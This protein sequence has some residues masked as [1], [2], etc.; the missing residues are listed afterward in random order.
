MHPVRYNGCPVCDDGIMYYTVRSSFWHLGGFLDRYIWF[1]MVGMGIN[2]I[3]YMLHL[4]SPPHYYT[5]QLSKGNTRHMSNRWA[6][7]I[8]LYLFK[9]S[10]KAPGN[11]GKEKS[12]I[13]SLSLLLNMSWLN[14]ALCTALVVSSYYGDGVQPRSLEGGLA[15]PSPSP[16]PLCRV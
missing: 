7:W 5:S 8:R 12:W 11:L 14:S 13:L 2:D 1:L 16:L 9:S 15:L 10:A 4:N 6:W 3:T